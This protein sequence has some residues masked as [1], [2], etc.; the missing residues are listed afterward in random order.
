HKGL[1][2]R[3]EDGHSFVDDASRL[4]SWLF[5]SDPHGTQMANLICAIDPHC[6][7]YVAK[8]VEGRQGILP[9]NAINWAI[10]RDVDII[11]M[12]FSI[13]DFTNNNQYSNMLRKAV[14]EADHKGIIQYC[15][16]HDEGWNVKDSW[17]ASCSETKVIVACNEFGNF[18]DR[19]VGQYDYKVHGTDISAGAVPYLESN[20]SI[21]GSSVA[22]A[23]V[24]GVSS[25]ML[26][27]RR[28]QFPEETF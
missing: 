24:A 3:I 10:S 25:L 12:S 22:T 27:C 26:S 17:P 6:E 16:H 4:G 19:H 21:S 28:M 1:W 9:D 18:S 11:S 7:L 13:P 20:D 15:S 8:V 23:I 2:P 14:T 5:A